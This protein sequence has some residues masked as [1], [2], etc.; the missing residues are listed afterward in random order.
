[1]FH[2]GAKRCNHPL[3]LSSQQ[4]VPCMCAQDTLAKQLE[5]SSSHYLA[6]AAKLDR[7]KSRVRHY[8]HP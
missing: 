6:A 5:K 4:G 3:F 2:S 8:L 7:M 1:M